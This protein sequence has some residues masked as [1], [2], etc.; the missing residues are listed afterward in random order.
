VRAGAA[1]I[2]EPQATLSGQIRPQHITAVPVEVEGNIE[3]FLVDVG[4]EVFEGQVLA[5]IGAAG[6][7]AASED[8]SNAVERYEEQ[9]RRAETA[10]SSAILEA[11]RADA[12]VQRARLAFERI[13]KAFDRQRT[14]FAAGATPRM[15]Y[16]RVEQERAAA[17][18]ELEVIEKAAQAARA[19]A[20]N[21]NEQLDA[22][23]RALAE[24]S[25]QLEEAQ[26]AVHAAEV[27]SPVD[28]LVVGRHGETGKPAAEAGPNLYEIAT[29]LFDLEVVV[30]PPPTM[31]KRIRPS[32]EAL[33]L[34]LDVSSS[35]L[36][37][38]VKAIDGP[39]VVVEFQS[40]I[41]EVK[42]GMRA[43]V[44]LRMD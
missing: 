18:G 34:I 3:A 27:R 39:R 31:L 30:E 28:G 32:Q 25:T 40:A 19:Q 6:L 23:R 21:A 4:Q 13:D 17:R 26:T 42:P 16:Q 8:A 37:G 11:A 24:K 2:Q 38:K 35:G 44:R 43:D 12:D 14:L 1:V 29:D 15:T 9:V 33:V 5:R 22:A 7:E 36:P 41:P 10:V 20:Q